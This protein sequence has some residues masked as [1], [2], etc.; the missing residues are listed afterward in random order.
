M[1]FQSS[2]PLSHEGESWFL[3]GLRGHHE[4]VVLEFVARNPGCTHGDLETQ[5]RTVSPG[6]A[7]LVAGHIKRLI[8]RRLPIIATEKAR[9]DRYD[10]L[11]NLLRS[12]LPAL[13]PFLSAVNFQPIE[14]LLRNAS[15]RL[16]EGKVQV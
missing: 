12:W 1:F 14:L 4:E 10:I 7:E 3:H 11:D 5:V 13:A 2:E 8:E 15:A 9:K 6:S 16:C